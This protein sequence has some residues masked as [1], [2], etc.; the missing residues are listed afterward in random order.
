M[1]VELID[2]YAHSIHLQYPY[3]F[4]SSMLVRACRA[5]MKPNRRVPYKFTVGNTINTFSSPDSF[6][7]LLLRAKP[8]SNIAMRT[9]CTSNWMG[10]QRLD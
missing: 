6:S 9:T 5:M 8:H 2:T 7:T 1:R 10:P 3:W 4:M